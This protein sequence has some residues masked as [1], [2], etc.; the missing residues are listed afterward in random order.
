MRRSDPGDAYLGKAIRSVGGSVSSPVPEGGKQERA[1]AR[2]MERTQPKDVGLQGRLLAANVVGLG[3]NVGYAPG[4]LGQ[5]VHDAREPRTSRK[6]RAVV[7]RARKL[8]ERFFETGSMRRK[9]PPVFKAPTQPMQLF[10]LPHMKL[11][12]L[13]DPTKLAELRTTPL[14]HQERVRDR[15]LEDDQPGLV[16][17]HGLGTGKTFSSIVVHDALGDKATVVVPAALKGNYVKEQ[18]RHTKGKP[19]PAVLETVQAAATRGTA[20]PNPL[21]IVDEAHKLR[22][23]ASASHQAIRDTERKKTLLLTASP[24]YNHPHDLSPLINLAAQQNVLPNKREDFERKYI[25]EREVSPSFFQRLR[26]PDLKPG[27]VPELNEAAAEELRQVYGK[28]VDYHQ[29]TTEGFPRVRREVV[30]TLMSP[31]QR[32]VYDTVMGKAPKWVA[33]KVK[34]GMPPS[35]REM[36]DLTAFL[37]GPRQVSVSTRGFD[38]KNPPQSPKIDM[39]FSRLKQTLDANERAKALVYSNYIDSGIVPYREKL[40]AAG[41]PF[42]EFTGSV[43]PK[44]RDQMVRDYNEGKLRALLISSAGGEGL[45]LKGTRLVQLLEPHWNQE[46]L[47]QVEGRAARYKSHAHLPDEEQEVLIEQYLA[48]LEPK[49]REGIAAI[50]FGK[51]RKNR[52]IAADEYLYNMSQDKERLIQQFRDLL[53]KQPP[54]KPLQAPALLPARVRSSH[55]RP[56]HHRL[57]PGEDA[58]LRSRVGGRAG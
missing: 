55:E 15:L 35:K 6:T 26:N 47:K 39:A 7:G 9:A 16:A 30:E 46:K 12:A 40:R 57:P 54:P 36:G 25:R 13:L 50:L 28:W 44:D 1:L 3:G 41:I 8:L 11:S 27:V 23:P 38:E 56:G 29:N 18:Q 19:P 17:V 42:G 34:S 24:F 32:E 21:L 20:T 53:P 49:E 4:G 10:L 45:D 37:T 48:H 43:N 31:A 33:E 52:P 58:D 22:D 51:S 5:L 2:I 14:P